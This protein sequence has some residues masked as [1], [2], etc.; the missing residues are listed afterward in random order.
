MSGGSGTARM[1][2]KRLGEEARRL[3]EALQDADPAD[4]E[5]GLLGEDGKLA[6]GLVLALPRAV[7]LLLRVIAELA[8]RLASLPP[9]R[10]EE[11]VARAREGLRAGEVSRAVNS[12]SRLVINM[13]EAGIPLLPRSDAALAGE[14]IRGIDYGK[15]RKALIYRAEE[16]LGVLRREVEEMGEN[17]LALVNLF[18]AVAPAANRLLEVLEALLGILQLPAEAMTYALWKILE[19]ID[20]REAARVLNGAARLIVILHRGNLILGDGSPHSR[21]VAERIASDFLEGV[22]AET[23]AEAL[24]ALAEEG[25]VAVEALTL[26]LLE[27]PE[28]LGELAE[29]AAVAAGAAARLSAAVLGKA[30]ALPEEQLARMAGVLREVLEEGETQRVASS[31]RELLGRLEDVS[32][33]LRMVLLRETASVLGAD[34]ALSPSSAA[35]RA[36]RALA[37]KG[38][39]GGAEKGASP[40]GEFLAGLDGERLEGAARRASGAIEEAMRSNPRVA[41]ALL[42]PVLVLFRSAARAAAAEVWGRLRRRREEGRRFHGS[43]G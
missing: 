23:L 28:L 3:L 27:R 37:G 38:K 35:E 12:L 32:P 1:E 29:A 21:G 20:W 6:E 18:S 39:R 4:L 19:D 7:S 10:A 5:L 33:G 30:A 31:M 13:H 14:V 11:L 36:N 15:L 8:E 43:G 9:E 34:W 24:A 25:S 22:D 41:I 26:R 40:L 42:R 2:G 17:P 16:R